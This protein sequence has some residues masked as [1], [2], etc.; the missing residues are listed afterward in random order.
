MESHC[1]QSEH[2]THDLIEKTGAQC[3]EKENGPH[4]QPVHELAGIDHGSMI[5]EGSA[6]RKA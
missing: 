5:T 2:A 4:P 3:K 6:M 1:R